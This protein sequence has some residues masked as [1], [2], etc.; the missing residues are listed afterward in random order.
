[1]HGGC[2]V[3]NVCCLASLRVVEQGGF[4]LD[5]QAMDR[6]PPREPPDSRVRAGCDEAS[7]HREAGCRPAMNEMPGRRSTP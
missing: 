1:M 7:L 4:H 5:E 3:E 6:A 2:P